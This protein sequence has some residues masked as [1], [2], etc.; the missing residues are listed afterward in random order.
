MGLVAAIKYGGYYPNMQE[1]N[2]IFACDS[3]SGCEKDSDWKIVYNT[4]K[5]QGT[6]SGAFVYDS[7]YDELFLPFTDGGFLRNKL[8]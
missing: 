2:F 5:W 4:T 6:I 7:E 3:S 8:H 1:M